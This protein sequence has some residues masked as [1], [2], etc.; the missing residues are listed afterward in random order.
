[1]ILLHSNFFKV[2][3]SDK[4]TPA[5]VEI[6]P[7]YDYLKPFCSEIAVWNEVFRGSSD[8]LNEKKIYFLSIP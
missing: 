1:V 6:A 4:F 5:L 2:K 8:A 7:R 3:K